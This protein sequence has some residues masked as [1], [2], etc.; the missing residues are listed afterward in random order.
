M[1][2]VAMR[3]AGNTWRVTGVGYEPSGKF[4]IE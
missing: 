2:V 4:T 1:T 3:T